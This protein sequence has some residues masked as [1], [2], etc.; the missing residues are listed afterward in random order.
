MLI[1][2]GETRVKRLWSQYF[3]DIPLTNPR[4]FIGR[5]PAKF[6]KG[7]AIAAEK[8][9]Q[10]HFPIRTQEHIGRYVHGVMRN[11]RAGGAK[12]KLDGAEPVIDLKVT[13]K[14]GLKSPRTISSGSRVNSSLL[15][16]VC[17]TTERGMRAVMAAFMSTGA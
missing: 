1:E 15:A 3:P 13:V 6:E 9:K 11:L 8:D 17:S 14:A 7:L 5:D 2:S 4:W 10:G 16:T 12:L